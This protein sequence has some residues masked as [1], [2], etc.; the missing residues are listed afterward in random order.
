[1][2]AQ[3][4]WQQRRFAETETVLKRRLDLGDETAE[5]WALYGDALD[6]QKKTIEAVSAY[7]KA[8]ELKPDSIDFVM[9]SVRFFGNKFV[10]RMRKENFSKF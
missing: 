5:L 9:R 3:S 2:A 4:F 10:T 7:Q 6:A 1:M 8:V